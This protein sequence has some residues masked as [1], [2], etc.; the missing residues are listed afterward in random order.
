MLESSMTTLMNQP[1]RC[2]GDYFYC[3][4]D[5][6]ATKI[7]EVKKKYF[8]LNHLFQFLSPIASALNISF[9]PKNNFFL[10]YW[11]TVFS[12]FK[13]KIFGFDPKKSEFSSTTFRFLFGYAYGFANR[14][15]QLI[16]DYRPEIDSS[17]ALAK[18][19]KWIQK[20]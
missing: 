18:T 12:Q 1:E 14:K 16:I 4:E 17:E 6:K 2:N 7:S 8:F 19:V 13:K 15:Q 20:K 11:S 10:A 5:P 3:M 9:E